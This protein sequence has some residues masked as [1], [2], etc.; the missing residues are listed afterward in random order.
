MQ[1]RNTCFSVSEPE[2]LKILSNSPN[3]Q[4]D[5]YPIP[6]WLP[7]ECASVLVPTITNIVNFSLTSG[8]F[9]HILKESVIFPL[10]KKSTLD[11]DEL[12]NY[13]PI[14]TSNLSVISKIIERVVKLSLI[15]HL[16]SNK[17]L[18]RQSSSPLE[19][20]DTLIIILH[21]PIVDEVGL[22]KDKSTG[23]GSARGRDSQ[24]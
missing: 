8:H 6:T 11:K 2:I 1:Q 22:T 20:T 7:K 4:S 13:C 3:K 24:Q 16:T 17:L 15:D 19:H 14:P 5:S 9:H 18:N 21:I 12:S 10:L 23:T